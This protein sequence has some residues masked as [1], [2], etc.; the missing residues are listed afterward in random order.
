MVA[1][2]FEF[3]EE[4][5]LVDT[6]VTEEMKRIHLINGRCGGNKTGYIVAQI[7]SALSENPDQCIIYAAPTKLVLD[8]VFSNR[9]MGVD[10]TRKRLIVSDENINE[11]VNTR[12]TEFLTEGYCGCL[13]ITHAALF[14]LDA[15]L[16][17]D[18]WVII[19][20]SPEQTVKFTCVEFLE[21]EQPSE[22][23][24]FN[25]LTVICT[26]NSSEHYSRITPSSLENAQLLFEEGKR[27]KYESYRHAEMGQNKRA[28]KFADI[29]SLCFAAASEHGYIYL[30]SLMDNETTELIYRS[31]ETGDMVRVVN[32]ASKVWLAS[33]DFE[34]G[35]LHFLLTNYHGLSIVPIEDTGIPLEH[36]KTNVTILPLLGGDKQWS[37]TFAESN[38][39][40]LEGFDFSEDPSYS[41]DKTIFTEL[42]EFGI[43]CIQAE[44]YENN[45]QQTKSLM[46]VNVAKQSECE[47]EDFIQVSTQSHGQNSY[48]IQNHAIWMAAL[49]PSPNE[50]YALKWF[51]REVNIDHEAAKT[52]LKHTRQY[53]P[54]YQGLARTSLRV[55]AST[56][57]NLFVVPDTASAQVL[58]KWIPNATIDTK[59]LFTLKELKKKKQELDAAKE[60]RRS[61][62][63]S[64]F[65]AKFT[66]KHGRMAEVYGWFNVDS[67]QVSRYKDEFYDEL[68][69]AGL[70]PE[71]IDEQRAREVHR[72]IQ[73][74]GMTIN[75]ACNIVGVNRNKYLR[76]KDKYSIN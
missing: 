61:I 53:A 59:Y 25:G 50:T 74:E 1:L 55:E 2:L 70:L 43:Y 19:D 4:V 57:P 33:A 67:K 76:D 73:L 58:L 48:Q 72:L 10:P 38:R 7:E 47:H 71:V 51:C 35:L 22:L 12:I 37:K 34:G 40:A 65:E 36:D 54:M 63:F 26:P 75:K 18:K 30:S 52:C 64:I 31:I 32:H 41:C 24:R 39:A 17:A 68:S 3:Y 23:N 27:L 49:L 69:K 15:N 20:E 60:Q 9:L 56:N 8:E 11:S 28:K 45:E 62:V 66:V 13:L 5:T 14:A 42:F 29:A 46:F 16:L 21:N 44:I 6:V